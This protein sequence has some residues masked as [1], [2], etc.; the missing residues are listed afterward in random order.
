MANKRLDALKARGL[1]LA[2][3]AGAA[4]VPLVPEVIAVPAARGLGRALA[5]ALPDRRRMM[6][7][8]LRRTGLSGVA[9]RRA[10]REAFDSYSRYWLELFRLPLEAQ[11]ALDDRVTV[12]GFEHL[13][14][15]LKAGRGVVM[16]VPHVGGWD[17]G[18]AW[19]AQRGFPPTVVA[20]ALEP[21]EL[22]Q[23]FIEVREA[24]GMEV[25]VLGP[26][27]AA[28]VV[29]AL[30]ANKVVCLLAD[31]DIS[32]DGVK[33]TFFGEETTMPAGPAVLAL[34]TGAVLMPSV[35]YFRPG[36]RH[37]VVFEPPMIVE[38]TGRLRDD[39]GRVTQA[40]AER[41]EA[42]IRAEPEQ[43]HFM[44][45]NWPSDWQS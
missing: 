45:P 17:F 35:I 12:D 42:L 25:I 16:A 10:V 41:F 31:R 29:E 20:E 28:A 21:P 5:V 14:R 26:N 2:F 11:G 30:D 38:G 3:R 8:H 40:L 32:G 22:L 7:R 44:Q 33:V 37:H 34:R 27:A 36:G 4:A 6:E 9:L 43:W 18:G 1:F 23:W 13:E 15:A 39:V 19:L 24:L